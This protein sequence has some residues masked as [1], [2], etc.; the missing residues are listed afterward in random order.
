[1]EI[2]DEK[3]TK[4][5][6]EVEEVAPGT[7]WKNPGDFPEYRGKSER[8]MT[9]EEKEERHYDVVH[10]YSELD[11]VR[12]A[13]LPDGRKKR[14][15]DDYGKVYL[16]IKEVEASDDPDFVAQRMKEIEERIASLDK[17]IRAELEAE[18]QILRGMV[19]EL[20]RKDVPEGKFKFP[21]EV[22]D[23]LLKQI[24]EAVAMSL[25]FAN[26]FLDGM[27][28]RITELDGLIGE[29]DQEVGEKLWSLY[30]DPDISVGAHGTEG[31]RDTGFG[32]EDGPLMKYGIGCAYD[33][34][35]RTVS[36]QDRGRIH[37]HGEL[38][39]IDLLTYSFGDG[40]GM[41]RELEMENGDA[42]SFGEPVP[43]SQYTVI[44]AIPESYSVTDLDLLTSEER[45]PVIVKHHSVGRVRK[46]A[47]PIKP[48]FIVGV[49]QDGRLNDIVWNSKFDAEHIRELSHEQAI[50][51]EEKERLA[52]EKRKQREAELEKEEEMRAKKL[53]SRLSRL[54]S[55]FK[56]S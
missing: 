12:Y 25:E 19:E 38:S 29:L 20:R 13:K 51:N 37:A 16:A 15:D 26:G 49:V 10:L 43:A 24:D 33:D 39:F 18:A 41:T 44:V 11:K 6:V 3:K 36:F 35:R 52:A 28:T 4:P 45:I 1:M 14:P 7:S 9:D 2:D 48:E 22:F 30:T 56:K 46:M 21:D 50:V 53:S 27:R 34:V 8:K 55:R 54:I 40:E 42:F 32:T 31:G 5:S 23:D 47:R 17:E